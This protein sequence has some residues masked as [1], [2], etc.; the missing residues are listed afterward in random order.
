[1]LT[2]LAAQEAQ[3]IVQHLPQSPFPQ[4]ELDTSPLPTHPAP[5]APGDQEASLLILLA[6]NLPPKSPQWQHL[7]NPCQTTARG[8]KFGFWQGG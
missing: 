6:L 8:L 1:M 3:P 7:P 2:I 4:Q 5:H